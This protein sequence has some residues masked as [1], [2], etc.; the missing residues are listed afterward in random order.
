MPFASCYLQTMEWV[1]SLDGLHLSC[2]SGYDSSYASFH[3]MWPLHFLQS[4]VTFWPSHLS[5][6]SG[7]QVVCLFAL[8]IWAYT[9][10]RSR[11]LG[12]RNHQSRLGA[13]LDFYSLL[14][15][16]FEP[17]SK[18]QCCCMNSLAIRHYCFELQCWCYLG[19]FD[20]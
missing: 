12:R 2:N 6:Q 19:A 18:H 7:G 10:A 1:P 8:S 16:H 15:R 20:H 13:L 11:H 3:H 4:I 17:D 9:R 14:F 5:C